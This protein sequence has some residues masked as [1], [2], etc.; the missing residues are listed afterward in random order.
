MKQFFR[1]LFGMDS[2]KWTPAE[3]VRFD[4]NLRHEDELLLKISYGQNRIGHYHTMLGVFEELD[5]PK[6]ICNVK[7]YI[8]LTKVKNE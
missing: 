5:K 7:A 4:K 1:K 2:L 3:L 6:M 8:N